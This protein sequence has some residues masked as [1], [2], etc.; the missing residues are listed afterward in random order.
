MAFLIEKGYKVSIPF[1]DYRYDIIIDDGEKLYKVQIK[2]ARYQDES[3]LV[4][5]LC[6]STDRKPYEDDIDF[7]I[8]YSREFDKFYQVFHSETSNCQSIQLR[9]KSEVSYKNMKWASDF[10]IVGKIRKGAR[11]RVDIFFKRE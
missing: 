11:E 8:A 7:I 3:Y 10:E 9:L 1:G 6:S 2:T 4:V 5:P